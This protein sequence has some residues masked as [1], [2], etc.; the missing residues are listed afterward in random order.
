MGLV[1]GMDEAGYGPNLGPLV[2]TVTAWE[3]PEAPERFDFWKELVP[4]VQ[5]PNNGKPSHDSILV[6]DSKAVYSAARGIDQLETSVL[7]ILNSLNPFPNCFQ[8]LYAHLSVSPLD[9]AGT[10]PWYE[11]P[12]GIPL[13]APLKETAI[14]KWKEACNTTDIKI[15]G[16]IS[17]LVLT[18][19][20][21]Q[22][23]RKYNSKGLAL[24]RASLALLRRLW[25]PNSSEDVLIIA[26]KHGGRNRYDE[27]LA[28]VLDEQFIFRQ[29]E[30]TTRSRY[31]VG[32]TVICFQT[33]AESHFP[34]AVASMVSKYLRELAMECFN[35]YWQTH[36]PD[37]K[38]TKGY[39]VD[40][41]RFRKDIAE[42]Q[43]Q[44]NISDEMLWRHR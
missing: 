25:D 5:Q 10:E 14:A 26:D 39:P 2:V 31:K 29:E 35:R 28:E 32:K 15:R 19:R 12:L 1:I 34:V 44:L 17:D 41:R 16:I 13:S 40:A 43:A 27:L 4:T 33:K 11:E 37:L 9:L 20:F 38:P 3:V 42:R 30:G 21:N 6:G 8:D 18:E 24:S 22:T 7:T 23:V 36:I